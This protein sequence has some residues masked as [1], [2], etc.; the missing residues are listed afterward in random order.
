MISRKQ[1]IEH[2]CPICNAAYGFLPEKAGQEAECN[3]CNTSFIIPEGLPTRMVSVSTEPGRPLTAEETAEFYNSP[4]GRAYLAS[5]MPSVGGA[6][7]RR[8]VQA[9]LIPQTYLGTP[10]TRYPVSH[11]DDEKDF[12]LNLGNKLK[13]KTPL[14]GKT[15]ASVFSTIVGGA[16][17]ALGAVI[18]AKC[19]MKSRS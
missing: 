17:V 11:H 10:E 15:R 5:E 6:L 13:V 16:L 7:A 19:G 3:R 4:A 14:D 2:A 18:A 1:L 12:E 8:T 9:D